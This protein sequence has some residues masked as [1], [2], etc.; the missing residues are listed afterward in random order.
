MKFTSLVL[1]RLTWQTSARGPKASYGAGKF[2]FQTPRFTAVIEPS[3]RF[4]GAL[5]LH[6]KKQDFDT[7]FLEFLSN[8]ELRAMEDLN[9]SP[10]ARSAFP[11]AKMTA[12]ANTEVFDSEGAYVPDPEAKYSG[13][14]DVSAILQLTGAWVSNNAWSLRFKVNQLKIHGASKVVAKDIL[15]GYAFLDDDR[16]TNT[17]IVP[18]RL[19]NPVTVRPLFLPD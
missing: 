9:I 16:E 19:V 13:T 14:Y 3:M 5:M 8:V 1:K 17:N 18:D 6:A 11:L 10:S 12:F 15:S 7:A 2:A 4:P